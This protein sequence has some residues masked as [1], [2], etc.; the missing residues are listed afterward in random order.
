MSQS[1]QRDTFHALNAS[2]W[3]EVMRPEISYC[4]GMEPE[5]KLKDTQYSAFLFLLHSGD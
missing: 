1:I 3:S 5:T 2:D 4:K